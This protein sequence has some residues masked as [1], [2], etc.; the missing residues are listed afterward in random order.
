MSKIIR[1]LLLLGVTLQ[2]GCSYGAVTSKQH[3]NANTDLELNL[4]V[5]RGCA[6]PGDPLEIRYTIANNG[7]EKA[8][9]QSRDRSVLDIR[10]RFQTNNGRLTVL[11]SDGQPQTADL[12]QLILEPRQSKTIT[13]KW[14]IDP[15]ISP[16]QVITI[17]G[18]LDLSE[19][20]DEIR[21]YDNPA[22]VQVETGICHQG[23]IGP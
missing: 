2:V 13:M 6:K 22:S 12:K 11:W 4:W 19:I 21:G 16:S 9:I 14:V 20:R 10:I 5:N 15:R 23:P 3:I 17:D 8:V 18:P 7:K 1:F